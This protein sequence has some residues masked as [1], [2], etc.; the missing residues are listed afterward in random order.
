MLPSVKA[1]GSFWI[2]L[3]LLILALPLNWVISALLAAMVHELGHILVLRIYSVPVHGLRIRAGGAI[4]DTVPM[5]PKAEFLC[6]LAGPVFSFLLLTLV[7]YFPRISLCA[8]IQGCF[9][10]LPIGDLD[11]A[12]VV[13]SAFC[14]MSEK[15]LANREK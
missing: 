2:F 5:E 14:L 9:N 11:G 3:T 13:K 1:E 7:R 8:L 15:A 10:L 12:R 6:A 4:L